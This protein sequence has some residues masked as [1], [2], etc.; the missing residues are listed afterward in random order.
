MHTASFLLAVRRRC[1][2]PWLCPWPLNTVGPGWPQCLLSHQHAQSPS[3]KL[4]PWEDDLST[5]TPP[6]FWWAAAS[7]IDF[8]LM[9]SVLTLLSYS[10]LP[11]GTM[12]PACRLVWPDTQGGTYVPY[13]G[14]RGRREEPTHSQQGATP[15]L[16]ATSPGT[17]IPILADSQP[18]TPSDGRWSRKME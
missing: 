17:Q 10:I 13:L 16:P 15:S 11:S 8:F 9:C 6:Q 18:V 1:A 14:F 3:C 7:V 2:S 5:H 12:A 4:A